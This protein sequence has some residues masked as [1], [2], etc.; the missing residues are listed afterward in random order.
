MK[1]KIL[2]LFVSALI[3]CTYTSCTDLSD[4]VYSEITEE[5]FM[6]DPKSL[7]ILMGQVYAKLGGPIA[8]C[9][10]WFNESTADCMIV[11]FR[12]VSNEWNGSNHIEKYTH[13][14]NPKN[15]DL[16]KLWDRSFSIVTA[17][18][19]IL[20]QIESSSMNETTKLQ[21]D[22]ELRMVRAY[23]YYNI[24]DHWGD[25]PLITSKD[26]KME[27]LTKTS[28]ADI[29]KFMMNEFKECLPYLSHDNKNMY[30]RMHYYAALALKARYLINANV[31]LDTER[32]DNV[33][34]FENEGLDECIDVCTE[35]I[36]DAGY[37]LEPD[38]FT[39]FK[40]ENEGSTENIFVIPFHRTYSMGVFGNAAQG[41][42]LPR[43]CLHNSEQVYYG[44]NVGNLWNGFSALPSMYYSFKSD[45]LRLKGWRVGL[46]T[47][48]GE[49]LKCQKTGNMG[50][51]LNFTIDWE[52]EE[53]NEYDGAR[54]AKYE[55]PNDLVGYSADN[56]FPVIRYADILLMKAE[57]IM[58]KN[59]WIATSEAVSLVNDVRNRSFENSASKDYYTT[60][61][62]TKEELL[63]ERRREFYG[64]LI[65]RTDLIRFHEFI[66]GK[67]E[68][69]GRPLSADTEYFRTVFPIPQEYLYVAPKV[70]QNYG[71]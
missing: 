10:V 3:G 54:L 21:Y 64:E 57:A 43:Y 46:Q 22:A 25:V 69:L 17:I 65:R 51:D 14:W 70:E 28:S 52:I 7:D 41:F 4:T 62:L 38:Y 2:S 71:Y 47:Y 15:A 6:S 24:I 48:N 33:Y 31:F 1:N 53:C 26:V 56:D 16:K 45:D 30:G 20:P 18:N 60:S 44:E 61:N 49:P 68:R 29:Y 12:N 67:W 58:R 23:V 39:N 37:K 19:L 36:E 11:P 66:G 40:S 59:N 34:P 42:N 63:E 55:F 8:D 13:T 9:S 5:D 50:D 27:E 35:I 32:K